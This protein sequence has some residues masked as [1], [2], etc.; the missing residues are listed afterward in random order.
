MSSTKP[1][2]APFSRALYR[3]LLLAYPKPFRAA[4]GDDACDVF[5]DLARATRE[6]GRLAVAGL[7]LRSIRE[8][9]G[10]GWQ[11]RREAR[12]DAPARGRV[13]LTSWAAAIALDVRFATRTLRKNPAFTVVVVLTLALGI[14]ANTAIFSVVN[15]V[16]FQPLPF[17][18]PDRLYR[19]SW[20]W[21]PG[22]GP[23]ALNP[24]KAVYWQQ[25]SEAFENVAAFAGARFSV[26]IEP[27]A[28]LIGGV[29][30]SESFFRV[31]GAQPALGRT[32]TIAEDQ[33]GGPAVA[34]VSDGLWR[35]LFEAEDDVLGRELML[36]G[37]PHTIIGVM[38]EG[39]RFP[40]SFDLIV[41]LRLDPDPADGAHNYAVVGRLGPGA[42]AER[43][44]ADAEAVFARFQEE[45]P[46]LVA[47]ESN[48]F[49]IDSY[50]DFLVSG[51]RRNLLFLF[52][53]VGVV[54]L[55][56]CVNVANLML[57]RTASRSKEVAVR[58]AL[59][60][61]R[62]QLFRQLLVESLLLVVGAAVL[63]LL[64]ARGVIGGFLTLTPLTVLRVDDVGIQPTVLL[65]TAAVAGATG[66]V[67]GLTS[68]MRLDYGALSAMLGDSGRSSTESRATG[69]L[70]GALVVAEVALA[71]ML[72][73]G[74]GLFTGSLMALQAVDF[75]FE[76]EGLFAM[77]LALTAER[78]DTP[79][80]SSQ[81][82]EAVLGRIAA[83]PGVTSVA[84]VSSMP[85]ERGLNMPAD[86]RVDGEYQRQTVEY[87]TVSTAYFETMGIPLLAGRRFPA[88]GRTAVPSAI[89]SET[90]AR[91]FWGEVDVVGEEVF[92]GREFGDYEDT[93]R[94]IIGVVADIH[95]RG[96]QGPPDETVFVLRQQAQPLLNATINDLFP[97]VFVIR[98]APREGLAENL[99]RVV[100]A[101]DPLQPVTR[102]RTLDEVVGDSMAGSW[103]NTVLM[104]SFAGLAL[105]LTSIGVY[106]VI[107]YSVSRRTREIGVRVALGATRG[108][109]M[110][111][112]MVGAA[113]LVV[114]G[115]LIGLAA[116]WWLSRAIESMLYSVTATDPVVYGA[117]SLVLVGVALLASALP[118]YRASRV[119]PIVALRAD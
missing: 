89:V 84:A 49:T 17:P 20:Q 40:G 87:R 18:E 33:P 53:A 4:H 55:I 78:Y 44:A 12:L 27:A 85:L 110:S 59:G 57:S 37:T 2:A 114:V 23:T 15:E 108:G 115:L 81:F 94:E 111:E 109:V 39:F 36:D 64:L 116:A 56:A 103:F 6:S 21:Q 65:F 22:S 9:A 106:G 45:F 90:F 99:R 63:G 62:L 93:P 7:W 48:A 86:A 30:V 10:S 25:H 26:A 28:E 100:A 67:F 69:R 42:T 34:I 74:A 112:V 83:Q 104:G 98:T 95:E 54:L 52:A 16:L 113:R 3:A 88:D 75:G 60:A 80:A 51:V 38:P 68:A 43:A 47:P 82:E 35:R 29:K 91:R 79:L 119:D 71:S 50:G 72:L 58:A 97:T 101:V 31:F 46:E 76:P 77:E 13:E 19:I 24:Q 8:V 5:V 107:A 105:L 73:V 14:G 96:I 61:G 118:A 1:R 92:I 41:P 66:I 11:E 117:V 70:R 32:F 102:F